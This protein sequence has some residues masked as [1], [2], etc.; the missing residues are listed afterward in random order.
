MNGRLRL[1]ISLLLYMLGDLL[2]M[3]A[4]GHPTSWSV[5][6][7]VGC[8]LVYLVVLALSSVERGSQ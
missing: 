2:G 5:W 8:A 1:R 7:L 3:L 4:V 6:T